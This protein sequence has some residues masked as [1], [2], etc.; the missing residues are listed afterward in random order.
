MK[1]S[2]TST[3]NRVLHGRKS[4]CSTLVSFAPLA[5][6]LI[7]LGRQLN[8]D[9]QTHFYNFSDSADQPWE[10]NDPI[11]G[12]TAPPATFTF[13]NGHYRI[14]APAQQAPACD[15]GP[16]R[17]GSFLKNVVYN[18]FYVS[19]DLID[20]DD[21]VRQVFGI[22]ARI[23]TPGLQTTGGYLFSW[24]PGSGSLP[25]DSNGDLDIS[26]LVSEAPT[27]QLETAS[28]GLHLTRGK[29]YRFV[30][31]GSGTNFEGQVYELPDTLHPL[32]R[33]P[34][35]DPNDLYPSGQVGLISASN[36]SCDI[37]A[38]A[39]WDNFL[40]TTAEPRLSASQSGGTVQISWPSM[41][42]NLQST[43]SLSSPVW[44]TITSGITQAGNRSIYVVPT[45]APTQS[46]RLT[47]P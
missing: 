28:S 29:S 15:A 42:F 21:T 41:P 9:A 43:P 20:F 30:F 11:G 17:A 37:G 12:L 46:Y 7:L 26:L 34:A 10:H 39:T 25:G 8:A 5:T 24:E 35:N 3:F 2:L 23:S 1:T 19:A 36:D 4:G 44:T 45:G 18:D 13:P 47:Y 14:Q 16:A 27:T 33:L 6:L 40:A 32:I 31:M 38:D 22:A